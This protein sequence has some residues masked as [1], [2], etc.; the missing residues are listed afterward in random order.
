MKTRNQLASQYNSEH[1][2]ANATVEAG[3][4]EPHFEVQRG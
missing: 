1:G 4:N 3:W 2:A